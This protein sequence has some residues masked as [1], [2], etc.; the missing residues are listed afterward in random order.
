MTLIFKSGDRSQ[1]MDYCGIA[2]LSASA[3]VFEKIVCKKLEDAIGAKI[4]S[5]QLGF[6]ASRSTATNLVFMVE[7]VLSVLPRSGQVDAVYVNLATAF[8]RA[9]HKI[10]PDKLRAV[11]ISGSL[12]CWLESYL[13]GRAQQVKIDGLCSLAF[14][15]TSGVPQ[16][17]HLDPLLFCLF[18]ND[19][20]DE[21]VDCFYLQYADDIFKCFKSFPKDLHY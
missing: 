5:A 18:I 7:Y 1:C 10:L 12:L 11:G 2:L 3:K 9:D 13:T 8:G 16:G 6:R 20:C 4:N 14:S 21:F 19:L 17:S 15:V